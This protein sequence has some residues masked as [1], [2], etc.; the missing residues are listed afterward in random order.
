MRSWLPALRVFVA[1]AARPAPGDGVWRPAIKGRVLIVAGVLTIWTVVIYG[2]LIQLQVFQ[3]REMRARADQQQHEVRRPPAGRGDILDRNGRL[4]A[5]SVDGA[6]IEGYPNMVG[7]AREVARE[8]CRRLG[9]CSRDE[10]AAM[11]RRLSQSDK[12]WIDL[13]APAPVS[14]RQREAFREA[15][16][17]SIALVPQT[18]RYYPHVDLAA[19]VLGFV[20]R[21]NHGLGGV[22]SRFDSLIRGQAGRVLVQRDARSVEMFTRVE[23]PPTAGASI[24]L[25]IDVTYQHIL[26]RELLAG[27]RAAGARAGSAVMMDPY[28]G[29]IL[30]LANY[31]TFNPNTFSE[32]PDA[33]RRNRAVQEVYEPGSTFK[34]V[35]AAAALEEGVLSTSELID[36][37][38]GSIKFPGRKP[39]T[40]AGGHNYGVLTFEDV[41]V[42]SSNVGA[43]RA[44]LRVGAERMA[45]FARRLGFGQLLAPDFSGESAGIVHSP[46]R[47]N[48]SDLASMSMG[49]TVSVTPIQMAAAVSAVAN[50]GLLFEPHIVRAIIKDGVRT[51]DAPRVLRRAITPATATTL[52]AIMEAVVERGTAKA[53]ALERYRVAGKTGTAAKIVNGLYSKTDYNS[54]FVGFVPSRRP[55]FTILVVIDTPRVGE[56]GGTVAAPVFR[57]IAEAVLQQAGVPPSIDPAPAIVVAADATPP[58][59]ARLAAPLPTLQQVGGRALM[60]DVRGLGARDALRVLAAAGLRV[61]I[62][63]VG[64]VV[65][66]APEAGVPIDDHTEGALELRRQV[67]M[68]PP[69]AGGAR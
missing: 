11:T 6:S 53:A 62:T 23:Q 35:T 40:E 8:L 69:S 18:L 52:T 49:Y 37:N 39:I 21:E 46:A 36:C 19:H 38:P 17:S 13:R 56:Y 7:Q 43:I 59:P 51:V 29:E 1:D 41:I 57:R 31:P 42:K 15:R 34:I 66:Q 27:I 63:G 45:R 14:P 25:T 26:E 2:R 60:P 30:A 64:T 67:P 24:E 22:E 5:Y 58:A 28:T 48:D 44:G 47:L 16:F 50:G 12:T 54:S 65:A 61:R 32:S 10:L 4:L 55:A 3:H 20:G 68:G 9:D 33:A